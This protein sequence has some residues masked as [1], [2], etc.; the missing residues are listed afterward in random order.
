MK[1][2]LSNEQNLVLLASRLTFSD[3]DEE[4][5][6][7]LLKQ[8]LDWFKIFRIALKNKVLNLFWFNFNTR[9][10][11]KMIP[12]N[13]E[14]IMHFYYLGTKE[15]NKVYI[16]DLDMV[17]SKMYFSHIDCVP[18][19]G[20]V[21]IPSLY[22]DFGIRTINDVDCMIKHSDILSVRIIMNDL[23]YIEGDYDS[24]TNSIV[25]VSREKNILWKNKMNNL[26]PFKKLSSSDFVNISEFDFCFSL[27]LELD[28]EPINI[29]ISRAE[30]NEDDTNKN[31]KASDCFIHLCCHLY[32]E[33]T[34]AMW[35]VLGKDLNLI[36]F[37][38]VREFILQKLNQQ[39]IDN[40]IK[41]ANEHNLTKAVY[42][43]LYYLNEIYNDGYELEIMKELNIS[44]ESFIYMFGNKDYGKDLKWKKTFWER[45]FADDNN[46]ELKHNPRYLSI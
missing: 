36:K 19:K 25:K 18:V 4:S 33:A 27:D 29:M 1:S 21:L 28:Y 39:E 44:D 12:P 9:G 46:D 40:A 5:L 37:C 15:R 11:I 7:Y 35:V 23:G 13:L 31:L 42:F 22:K 14:R 16:K 24:R 38:D 8:E 26:L 10:Y 20:G 6:S 32:K 2:N 30:K 45:L 41:F 3:K 34:N 17:L 43:T